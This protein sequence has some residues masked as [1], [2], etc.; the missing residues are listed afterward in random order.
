MNLLDFK[1]IVPKEQLNV[2]KWLCS[3]TQPS[4]EGLG[5]TNLPQTHSLTQPSPE[6]LGVI[7]QDLDSSLCASYHVYFTQQCLQP[8]KP[9]DHKSPLTS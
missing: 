3:T 4:P 1:L 9:L 5:V 6:G 8:L 7:I 2:S